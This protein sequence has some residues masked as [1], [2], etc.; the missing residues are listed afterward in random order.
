MGT[1]TATVMRAMQEHQ[2]GNVEGSEA[3]YREVLAADSTEPDALHYLGVLKFQNGKQLEGLALIRESLDVRPENAHAWNSLG[4]ILKT[5]GDVEGG[6][7]AYETALRLA[8]EMHQ[9]WYN[10]ARL[11]ARLGRKDESIAAL[12]KIVAARPEYEEAY[13]YLGRLCYRVGDIERARNTYRAWLAMSP[14]NPVPRHMLAATG[15]DEVSAPARAGDQYV[16]D[17]F[18]GYAAS[19]DENLTGLG[20]RAPKLMLAAVEAQLDAAAGNLAILDAGCGTGLCGPLLKPFANRLDGVDLSDKMVDLARARGVY[21]ELLVGE[22]SATMRER[23]CSYDAIISA[24][25]L[26]YFGDLAEPTAAAATCLR[27]DGWFIFTVEALGSENEALDYRLAP[28][29]RYEHGRAYLERTLQQGGFVVVS[30]QRETL[31]MEKAAEVA[32]WLVTGR[33]AA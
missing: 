18:N 8:P 2:R 24:D 21:D 5:M 7:S 15:G 17:L 29:G 9:A 6:C 26:V 16:R 33:L 4:N 32:G 1:L 10:Y 3:I 14:D 25:T 13:Q 12:E 23:P 11:L 20:Y 28:S 22:L 31:R 19:F 27:P 30:I